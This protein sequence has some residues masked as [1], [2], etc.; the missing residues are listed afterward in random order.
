MF[1]LVSYEYIYL[2]K[3]R[4][5]SKFPVRETKSPRKESYI[6]KQY[7]WP[8]LPKDGLTLLLG[9]DLKIEQSACVSFL[10]YSK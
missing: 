10:N 3:K 7:I 1:F 5:L 9:S 2:K 6:K 8:T 4:K